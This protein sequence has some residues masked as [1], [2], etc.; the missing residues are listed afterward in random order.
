MHRHHFMRLVASFAL[1]C[2]VSACATIPQS[3]PPQ[4]VRSFKLTAVQVTFAPD[5]SIQW[6]DGLQ[7]WAKSKSIPDHEIATAGDSDEAR[8]Y[9]RTLLASKIREGTTAVWSAALSGTHPA[10]INVVVKS[11]VVASAAQRVLIGGSHVM[12]ADVTL[13]DSGGRE[14]LAR[15]NFVVV[16]AAGQGVVGTLV[17]AAI[18]REPTVRLIDDF[19]NRY[20]DWLLPPA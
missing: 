8:A 13:V 7:A 16:N 4:Q 9:G 19:A 18:L 1:V 17:D 20:R 2:A 6:A 12:S 10:R 15:P 5:A 14:L 3:L 11:F